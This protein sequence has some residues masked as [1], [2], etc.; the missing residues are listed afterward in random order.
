MHTFDLSID[1]LSKI[2]GKA[3]LSVVVKDDAVER[4]K[5]AITEFK[6]FYTQAV[7]GKDAAAVP[8]LTARI[9]GTC[10]NAHLLAAVKAIE[11]ALKIA[12]TDQTQQLRQL[13]HYG[14]MIRDHAL[15]LYFFALP[16][17]LGVDSL[18]D[19][20]ETNAAY[21]QI[22]HDAFEIKAAGNALGKIIGGRSVH[23]PFV[24]VGGFT[25]LP[26]TDSVKKLITP[27]TAVRPAVIRTIDIFKK[28]S[29][30]LDRNI[31]Y[32]SL[33]SADFNFLT[34]TMTSDD[35][36]VFTDEEYGKYLT[37][38][39]IPHSHASGY[40]F[41]SETY[42]VGALARINIGQETLHRRTKQDAADA[43]AFFPS[44]NIY[45]NNLAQAI[46]ILHAI[47][48]SVDIIEGLSIKQENP[49]PMVRKKSTGRGIIEAPRGTLYYKL[50]IADDGKITTVQI[51]VPTGQNQISIE[52]TIREYISRNLSKEKSTLI[53][54]IEQIVRAYDPCMSCAS[55]FLKVS[56]KTQRDADYRKRVDF[57]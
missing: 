47:D 9:C 15:H 44:R 26:D 55:H 40:T 11:H 2:E 10:S 28:C 22:L 51:V 1:E 16:D 32:I 43:L 17:I 31:K 54:E 3:R 52:D 19:L 45:H 24:G 7:R 46:E 35:G 4:V 29:F 30:R 18:L 49:Q 14:L 39:V 50:G 41:Q 27:L 48:A 25:R 20:D 34:G 37:H 36:A 53:Q 23:A 38:I 5:F 56:W 13:L 8:Q 33:K 12:P 6:R 21:H 57:S 42:M